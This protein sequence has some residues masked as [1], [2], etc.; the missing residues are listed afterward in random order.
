[1]NYGYVRVSTREQNADRQVKAMLDYG[2]SQK[3]IFID[4]LSG[5]DFNRPAYQRLLRKIKSDDTLIVKNI[6]RLGRNYDEILQEWKILT[7]KMHVAIIVLDMPLLNTSTDRDLTGKLIADIVL[8]LLSYVAH[9]ERESIHQR[10]AEGIKIAKSKGIRFGRPPLVRPKEFSE[11]KKL[12]IQKQ[13][14]A[15]VAAKRLGLSY[16]TF[17]RWTK[18]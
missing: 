1:M 11:I 3:C 4:K 15:K 5:K 8:Q 16:S 13:I 2:L 9:T 14:S 17:L 10:Q 18:Q 6:D 12:Y 7:H